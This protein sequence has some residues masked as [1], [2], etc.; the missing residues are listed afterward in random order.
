MYKLL[1]DS[2]SYADTAGSFWFSSKDEAANL[3][4]AIVNNNEF[5]YLKYKTKLIGSTTPANG[6]LEDAIIFVPLIQLSLGYF[7]PV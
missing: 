3:D 2:S 7:R 1:G 6:I 4:N 5:K